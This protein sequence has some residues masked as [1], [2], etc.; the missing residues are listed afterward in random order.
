MPISR[1]QWLKLRFSPPVPPPAPTLADLQLDN[2]TF[3]EDIS[4][5]AVIANITGK[6][7][8]STLALTPADGRFALN[9]QQ[10]QILRGLTAITDGDYPIVLTETLAGATNT[11]KANNFTLE[12]TP[13]TPIADVEFGAKTRSGHGGVPSGNAPAS[14][15]TGT[16]AS[17]WRIDDEGDLVPSGTYGAVK[18]FSRSSYDLTLANA[19][20]VTITMIPGVAHV[21][22][23]NNA[24]LANPD[25]S[26]SFQLR[27]VLLAA[28]GA[29][30]AMIHGE[31]VRVRPGVQN[32]LSNGTL[33]GLAMRIRPP[34]GGYG[35]PS[36]GWIEIAA[37]VPVDLESQEP[38]VCRMTNLG[39]DSVLM[40]SGTLDV[41]L[42]FSGFQC[43][44]PGTQTSGCF[45]AASTNGRKA[46]RLRY[47][48]NRV[49]GGV[50]NSATG[51]D[52]SSGI[53][54]PTTA[55][56]VIVENNVFH[57]L[58]NPFQIGGEA[59][60][61]R[62]NIMVRAY[63]DFIK[64]SAPTGSIRDNNIQIDKRIPVG[65]GAHGDYDQEAH[66]GRPAGV[67]FQGSTVTRHFSLTAQTAPYYNQDGAIV[68]ADDPPVDSK[69]LDVSF[70]QIFGL[71][72]QKNNAVM[73][74]N[75]KDGRFACITAIYEPDS[76]TGAAVLMRGSEDCNID[77]AYASSV[78]HA[79]YT[80]GAGGG[81][82]P[83]TGSTVTNSVSFNPT[84]GF[85]WAAVAAKHA[86]AF[87]NPRYGATYAFPVDQV[88]TI[89]AV[90][91][92]VNMAKQ[93]W[94]PN[95]GVAVADGGCMLPDGSYVGAFFPMNVD[96]SVDWNDGTVYVPH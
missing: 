15:I 73:A 9:A 47:H 8:G 57:D 46:S 5:G 93:D 31:E 6:T 42:S 25:S 65:I 58:Y 14:A 59:P 61:V 87:R 69:M 81:T 32:N 63:N 41:G 29:P 74:A 48:Y 94:S 10:T 55:D 3:P 28:I 68:F 64:L 30:G 86:V 54:M 21:K 50:L 45:T 43:W 83:T 90:M 13:A 71:N 26:S 84:F 38:G 40:S 82:V 22:W 66:G 33:G 67:N 17:D 36:D 56:N 75:P 24:L 20:T 35:G 34:L 49:W 39:V 1:A 51:L 4:A 62:N 85:S 52:I 23:K 89:S 95:P 27:T 78:N 2:L 76:T 96:G 77:R 60:V 88:P 11:P 7:A 79:E 18:T 53:Y 91:A 80:P 16:G 92:I 70:S 12:A 37:D 44:R 19:E 72:R